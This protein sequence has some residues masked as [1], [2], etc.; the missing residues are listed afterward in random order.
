[1]MI[2]SRGKTYRLAKLFG[3]GH[4]ESS[5]S[6]QGIS[7]VGVLRTPEVI[8]HHMVSKPQ[9]LKVRFA[10]RRETNLREFDLETRLMEA[11]QKK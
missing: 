6:H 5:E 9:D 3:L 4:L 2:I 7:R 10:V 1:M 11:L 8:D